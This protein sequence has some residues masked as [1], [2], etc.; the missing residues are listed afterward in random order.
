MKI[1]PF[2]IGIFGIKDEKS[3]VLAKKFQ[4]NFCGYVLNSL[5]VVRLA[6]GS[7]WIP[8]TSHQ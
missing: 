3:L 2:L 1:I 6:A 8:F 5:S 7:C 4:K